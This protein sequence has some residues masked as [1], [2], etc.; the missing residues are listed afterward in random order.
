M[1]WQAS[2][3]INVAIVDPLGS[4]T[5]NRRRIS[6]FS[7]IWNR[8]FDGSMAANYIALQRFKIFVRD[9]GI[10]EAAMS[11]NFEE[12]RVAFATDFFETALDIDKNRIGTWR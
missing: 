10:G 9:D 1:I 12:Q 6:A 4:L 11:D 3:F 7:V 5:G 8:K 2:P